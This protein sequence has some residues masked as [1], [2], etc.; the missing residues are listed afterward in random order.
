MADSAL[1]F[2]SVAVA[3]KWFLRTLNQSQRTCV[4]QS[5]TNLL[6]QT[7]IVKGVP[8]AF[9]KFA[10]TL[11]AKFKSPEALAPFFE[12]VK[13]RFS[14]KLDAKGLQIDTSRPQNFQ[15]LLTT[16]CQNKA[17]REAYQA[18][19]EALMN[20]AATGPRDLVH[21]PAILSAIMHDRAH[22]HMFDSVN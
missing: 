7:A 20:D 21:A 4:P 6:K 2:R 11:D 9:K 19:F 3:S 16:L 17:P 1:V 12:D 8:Q 5:H 13:I 15:S 14:Q 10:A 18:L 22:F